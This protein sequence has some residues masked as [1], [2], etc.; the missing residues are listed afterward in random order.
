MF[1]YQEVINDKLSFPNFV[2][3]TEE[4]V[5]RFKQYELSSEPWSVF[6]GGGR[7]GE[8]ASFYGNVVVL[9]FILFLYHLKKYCMPAHIF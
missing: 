8:G 2:L 7:G 3:K 6:F 1:D 5:L 9:H 4:K